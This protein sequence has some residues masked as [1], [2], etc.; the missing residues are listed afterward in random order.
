MTDVQKMTNAQDKQTGGK[1]S[2]LY[3]VADNWEFVGSGRDSGGGG[4]GGGDA[5]PQQSHEVSHEVSQGAA[6]GAGS[7]EH[8][9]VDDTPF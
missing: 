3:V 6:S 8:V 1:R 2:K 5:S 9:E 7:Y 4:G